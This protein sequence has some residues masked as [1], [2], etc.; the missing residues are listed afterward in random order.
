MFNYTLNV[1]IPGVCDNIKKN[2]YTDVQETIP[3]MQEDVQRT[4]ETANMLRESVPLTSTTNQLFKLA[5][6]VGLDDKDTS[7]MFLS[8]RLAI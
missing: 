8:A 3:S 6:R 5:R 2:S 1:S 4:L 7:A